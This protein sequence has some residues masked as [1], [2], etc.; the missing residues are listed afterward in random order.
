MVRAHQPIEEFEYFGFVLKMMQ[1]KG[2]VKLM[3][4]SKVVLF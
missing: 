3:G 2:K 1:P 4:Q